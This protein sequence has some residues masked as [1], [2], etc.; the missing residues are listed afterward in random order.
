M[1]PLLVRTF[2]AMAFIDWSHKPLIAFS[3]VHFLD[4]FLHCETTCFGNSYVVFILGNNIR[5]QLFRPYHQSPQLSFISDW[6][7]SQTIILHSINQYIIYNNDIIIMHTGCMLFCMNIAMVSE[8]IQS[9]MQWHRGVL[10]IK[11]IPGSP[12]RL[13]RVPELRIAIG[14]Q[15]FKKKGLWNRLEH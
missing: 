5:L 6:T 9:E 13:P 11:P 10:A 12:C 8:Y 15:I 3:I 2:L 4:V 7:Y 1:A 14:G